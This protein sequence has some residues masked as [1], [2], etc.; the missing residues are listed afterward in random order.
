MLM[1]TPPELLILPLTELAPGHAG[2][3][4]GLHATDGFAH[5]LA[6]MG[7]RV[8]RRV[9]VVR[10]APLGGPIQVRLGTTDVMLRRAEAD[11]IDI[12]PA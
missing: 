7:F 6:A 1:A 4:R 12:T 8:G 2:V 5:R 10:R 3:V 11:Y 9:T